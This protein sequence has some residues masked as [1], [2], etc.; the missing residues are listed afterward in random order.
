MSS[1][2]WQPT[3]LGPRILLRPI[4]AT[5][6]EETF[7]AASDPL[8]W[9]QHSESD[10]YTRPVFQKFFQGALESKGGLV[11]IDRAQNRII[12]STRYYDWNP[13]ERSV[14]IGYSFLER[15]YWGGS[16]NREVKG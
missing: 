8:I 2:D 9:E 11:V 12:G 14:V 10:R 1:P 6:F 4:T 16:F 3:L 5:D 15:A 7:R 13:R